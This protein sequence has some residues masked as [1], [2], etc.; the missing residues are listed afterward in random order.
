MH[1]ASF[2]NHWPV[3][4]F[5]DNPF[6]RYDFLKVYVHYKYCINRNFILCPHCRLWGPAGDQLE[7]NSSWVFHDLLWGARRRSTGTLFIGGPGGAKTCAVV[8]SL[9]PDAELLF[10]RPGKRVRLILQHASDLSS[11]EVTDDE[12]KPADCPSLSSISQELSSRPEH[13]DQNSQTLL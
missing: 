2:V 1:L 10:L 11:P 9:W 8:L 13:S 12:Y 6:N 7:I 4:R 5:S 3:Q